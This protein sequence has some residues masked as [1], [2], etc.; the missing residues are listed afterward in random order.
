MSGDPIA[1]AA[2]GWLLGL[3]FCGWSASY[4]WSSVGLAPIGYAAALAWLPFIVAAFLFSRR[5]RALSM[6]LV[7]LILLFGV[8]LIANFY[9]DQ[10]HPYGLELYGKTLFYVPVALLAG[11]AT[12][13]VLAD[14]AVAI[15]FAK[16]T[17]YGFA[18]FVITYAM[19]A[20]SKGWRPGQLLLGTDVGE[21]YQG[22]SRL[23]AV[24]VLALAALR[25]VINNVV[26]WICMPVGVVLVSAFLG[27]GALLGVLLAFLWLLAASGRASPFARLAGLFA[28]AVV[29]GAL[30]YAFVAFDLFGPLL[31]FEERLAGKADS[32]AYGYESRPWLMLQGLKLW[33]SGTIEFLFGPGLLR[34]S[35]HVGHCVDFRHPHNLVILFLVW[36]GIMSIPFLIALAGAAWRALGLLRSEHP[37]NHLFGLLFVNYGALSL[38]GGDLEQNRHLF[39]V[40]GV[41]WALA[42]SVRRR[43]P[44]VSRRGASAGLG[45]GVSK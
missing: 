13:T 29:V 2:G 35:C 6:L 12:G 41:T 19:Y 39:Y 5:Y 38:L 18:A 4:L 10:R 9:F 7:P 1:R 3:V 24:A 37:V 32:V 14:R 20:L 27:A 11:A 34:Y 22:I 42:S 15:G 16:A 31:Q 44:I 21:Y 33:S 30:V 28:V 26:V 23:L 25:P 36:F 43:R 8:V 45:V 17:G 40:A